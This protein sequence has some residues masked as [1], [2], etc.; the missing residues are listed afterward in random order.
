M[1]FLL[2]VELVFGLVDLALTPITVVFPFELV[3]IVYDFINYIVSGLQF[4]T[5]FL[6]DSWVIRSVFT[7]MLSINVL[8]L[9]LDLL[10]LVLGYVKLKRDN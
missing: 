8:F 10:W 9:A 4:V 6:F 2:L 7:F 5:F 1:I 3:S